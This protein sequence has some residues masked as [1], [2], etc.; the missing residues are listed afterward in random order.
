MDLKS[1]SLGERIAAGSGAVFFVALFL[2]WLE[3]L[4]A[5][6]LFDI[7]DV[8]LAL[9]ALVAVVLPLAKATGAALPIRPSNKAILTR[10]GVIVLTVT[11]AF[12]LE[13]ADRGF[14][15][16]LAVLAAA[17]MLYGALT[18]PGDE[19]P[20]R[21]RE[22]ARRPLVEED[23]EEPPPGME[24]WRATARDAEEPD[25]DETG[26][27]ARRPVDEETD[28]GPGS[29][30]PARGIEERPRRERSFEEI[31]FDPEPERTETRSR[32][33]PPEGPPTPDR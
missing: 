32:R 9:L 22:R 1:M 13:G 7:V 28:P 14:G 25:P 11:V 2:S 31:E 3:A 15:I 8:L 10:V 23:Y 21:R 19:A 29:L 33:L 18:M 20:S 30:Q 24:S 26:A 16:F 6:Q 12:F 4:T 27:R 17:G 5:W